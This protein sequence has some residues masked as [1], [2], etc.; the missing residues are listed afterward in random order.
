MSELTYK[1]EAGQEVFTSQFLKN[2]GTC[3]KTSCLHCPYGFTLKNNEIEFSEISLS[4]ISRAQS[5]INS[6]SAATSSISDSLLSSAFG[7]SKKIDQI[8][9]YNLDKFVYAS[10]K[11]VVFG[12]VKKGNLQPENL[13]LMEQ[14]KN[15][16]IDLDYIRS[17]F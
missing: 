3:C 2:R 9:S 13:Y 17:C 15:Q 1:N 14:F 11:G 10:I 4:E 12:V 5:I 8:K 6:N 16:G 7:G